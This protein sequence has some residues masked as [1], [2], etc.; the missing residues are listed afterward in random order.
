MRRWILGDWRPQ[1]Y[2]LSTAVL[3]AGF[4][5]VA[6]VGGAVF[7]EADGIYAVRSD[8]QANQFLGGYQSTSVPK[9]T[10]VLLG[11]TVITVALNG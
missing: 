3:L 5:V 1:Q 4:R 2:E 7:S 11:T 9:Q 10:V 6:G 8:F